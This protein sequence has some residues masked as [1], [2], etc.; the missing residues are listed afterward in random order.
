MLCMAE[1]SEKTKEEETEEKHHDVIS[2]ICSSIQYRP[3]NCGFV[4]GTM[5]LTVLCSSLSLFCYNVSFPRG[6]E[7]SSYP[8]GFDL[9]TGIAHPA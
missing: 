6:Q 2:S 8:G 4:D 5:S 3:N 7:R 9:V 1:C